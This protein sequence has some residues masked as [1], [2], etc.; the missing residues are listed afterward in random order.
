[1]NIFLEKYE[2]CRDESTESLITICVVGMITSNVLLFAEEQLKKAQKIG[3]SARR[4][5]VNDALYGWLNALRGE[6]PDRVISRLIFLGAGWIDLKQD[7]I[8]TARAF[9]LVN[10]YYRG[11]DRYECAYFRDFFLNK[12][13]DCFVRVVDKSKMQ[14]H[15]WTRTKER[16]MTKDLKSLDTHF[17]ELR[18]RYKPIY[19]HESSAAAT[20]AGNGTSTSDYVLVDASVTH[21]EQFF[22]WKEKRAMLEYHALL[23]Q[24]LDAIQNPKT[25]LDLYV[26]GKL[27]PVIIPEIEAY[28]LK[29]LFIDE[30]KIERLRQFAPPEALNF[31]LLPIRVLEKGDVADR[32][33]SEYNGLMGIRYFA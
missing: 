9:K 21:R 30:A 11:G 24:R 20:A 25:N 22:E 26:F 1:M 27:R 2:N 18:Q 3:N 7:Q 16:S 12:E 8:D 17:Q 23:Q 31:R 14:V 28:A 33:I 4:K 5:K 32:F 29:E 10:P 15:E 13:F 6:D 19:I